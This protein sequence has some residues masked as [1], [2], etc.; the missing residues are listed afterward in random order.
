MHA[1]TS[2]R[3]MTCWP[4]GHEEHIAVWSYLYLFRL[5]CIPCNIPQRLKPESLINF[6]AGLK[7]CPTLPWDT[8]K[9]NQRYKTGSTEQRSAVAIVYPALRRVHH[10]PLERLARYSAVSER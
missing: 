5:W 7:T 10:D 9:H 2:I 6:A 3:A 4:A 1:K 8:I